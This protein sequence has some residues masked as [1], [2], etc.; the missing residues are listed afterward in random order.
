[1]KQQSRLC[2][3]KAKQSFIIG[4][5]L[6]VLLDFKI[7]LKEKSSRPFEHFIKQF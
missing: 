1:M 7:S 2:Y 6:T 5:Y 3:L 4:V